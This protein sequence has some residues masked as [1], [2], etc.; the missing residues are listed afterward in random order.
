MS[1]DSLSHMFCMYLRPRFSPFRAKLLE[2]EAVNEHLRKSLSRASTRQSFYGG[3][4]SFSSAT[5]AP[6]KETSDIIE[7]AKKDLEKLK[8]RERKK[9]KR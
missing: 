1:S 7:M 2:S 3:A 5:L 6:E 4:G 9:K 8:K